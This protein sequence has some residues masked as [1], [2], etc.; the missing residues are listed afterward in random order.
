MYDWSEILKRETIYDL[1]EKGQVQLQAFLYE[2]A[3]EIGVDYGVKGTFGN[4]NKVRTALRKFGFNSTLTDYDSSAVKA[5][6]SKGL[7]V[8]AGGFGTWRKGKFLWWKT[9]YII[10][11]DGHTW[12]IDGIAK[13]Q[14]NA[15]NFKIN[16][17]EIFSTNFM[18]CNLGWG[19]SYNGYYMDGLFDTTASIITD[20][21]VKRSA[22]SN[23]YNYQFKLKLITHISK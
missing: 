4:D 16:K 19:G 8:Y 3:E 15:W 17:G 5:S 6:L 22:E 10:Y 2:V 21:Q 7:P 11:N 20:N 13:L 9:D 1:T 23:P 18:H 14:V 12:V